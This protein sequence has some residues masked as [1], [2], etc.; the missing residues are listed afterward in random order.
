MN[1]ELIEFIGL[2]LDAISID[3]ALSKVRKFVDSEKYC[4]QISVNAA[5]LVYAQKDRR[6]RQAINNADIINADGVPIHIAVKLIS[7]RKTSRMGG[8]DYIDGLAQR[9]P[10][11]RYY[12]LGA[13]QEV[14]DKVVIRLRDKYGLNIVGYRNG[15]FS[16]QELPHIIDEIN[17]AKADILFLA[18]GTPA[19]EYLLHD[20][21]GKLNVK[22]AVGVGGAFDII[23]GQTKRAPLW[24]QRCGMEWFYRIMQEPRRMW[25]RYAKTNP[26]FVWL[27]IKEYIRMRNKKL[28]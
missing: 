7:R 14:V 26:V 13:R 20:L 17:T 2:K 12:L 11:I 27:V 25:K 19:K 16:E 28:N 15:Y 9:Y 8:Y 5:K 4:Y 18:I 24:I 21:R 3:Q 1:R 6:L 22:F 10:D 23:A